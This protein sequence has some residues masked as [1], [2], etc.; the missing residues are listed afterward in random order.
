MTAPGDFNDRLMSLGLSRAS[1]AAAQA[2]APFIGRGDERA[3]HHAA[4]TAMQDQLAQMAMTGRIVIGEGAPGQTPL[5]YTGQSIGTGKGPDVDIALDPLEGSTLT[6]KGMA[7][8]MTVVAMAPEGCL[9]QVPQLYMEKLA[10]G[11]GY[12][13]DLIGLDMPPAERVRV[14]A[15]ARGCNIGDIT[16]CILER[17]RHEEMIAELRQA[18]AA[19]RLISDGDIPGVIHVAE[20]ELTGIDV[21]MGIGGAPEGVLAAC[22]L[23]CMG[24]QIWGRLALRNDDDRARARDAGLSQPDRIYGLN[25]MVGGDVIFAATGVTNGHIVAGVQREPGFLTTET[26]L[27]RSATGSVRRMTYRNPVN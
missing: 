25:D 26:I 7:N 3:A 8:A 15:Q 1:E 23:K 12:A 4:A 16:V 2:S 6:A 5:L 10:I 17:P 22:A 19:I 18:G 13:T 9:L 27:M 21:Y 11:P 24:G 20:P 14:L